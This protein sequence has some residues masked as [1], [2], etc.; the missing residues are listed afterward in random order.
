VGGRLDRIATSADESK[1]NTALYAAYHGT[2]ATSRSDVLPSGRAKLTRQISNDVDL[3]VAVGHTARVAE[4]NERFFALRRMGTDWVGNPDLA[5]A[6]NTGVDVS[7]SVQRPRYTLAANGY[8]YVFVTQPGG[9]AMRGTYWRR[10][11]PGSDLSFALA[12]IP[13]TQ[14]F[15]FVHA[16]DTHIH[17]QNVERTRRLR[18]LVDSL[19]PSFV[20]I[21]GDL[22]R[23]ALRVPE[24][25][26]RAEY[27]LL[28]RE[29]AAFPVPVFTVPGNH[30]IFG[31]E[32]QHSLVG[33]NNPVYGKRL[34]RTVRGPNYY[35]FTFGG[36]HFM[37]LDTVDYDDLWYYGHV[38]S[39]QMGWMGR[40]VA[41]LPAGMRVVTFNHI[42]LVTAAE[43][44]DGFREDGPAPTVIRLRGRA[45]FRHV[46]QNA[47]EIVDTSATGWRS[48]SVDTC[49][50]GGDPLDGVGTRA[51][52]SRRRSPCPCAKETRDRWGSLYRVN[53][54]KVDDGTFVPRA[55]SRET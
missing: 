54:G 16:S 28:T 30:D 50:S 18:A 44:L 1:A 9:Y 5:P 51:S 22:I 13:A 34:H 39:V 41:R 43:T 46:V 14:S 35:S 53:G 7:M 4:A 11:E 33:R 2:T 23:D 8:G 15:T 25:T 47:A 17:E 3:A 32:R 10:A 27:D 48:P 37:G 55:V 42:P 40:D 26:A 52:T 36:M 31:I 21:T 29:L 12:P 45:Y 6:R 20:I 38:D 49:T 24:A 19:R